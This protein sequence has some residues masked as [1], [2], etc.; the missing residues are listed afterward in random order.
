MLDSVAAV[1]TFRDSRHRVLGAY[2]N[3]AGSE[4]TAAGLLS[5]MSLSFSVLLDD[6][7]CCRLTTLASHAAGSDTKVEASLRLEVSSR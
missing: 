3:A 4:V 6:K 2:A 7:V 1:Q 5:S